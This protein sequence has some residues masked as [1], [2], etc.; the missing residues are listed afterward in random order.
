MDYFIDQVEDD[1]SGDLNFVAYY[2][3]ETETLAR[4]THFW[5][6]SLFMARELPNPIFIE[7]VVQGLLAMY[8]SDPKTALP[9]ERMIKNALLTSSGAYTRFMYALCRLLRKRHLL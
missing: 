8:L 7:T 5:Q 9:Q 3:N 2:E 1:S 6:Q 4:L